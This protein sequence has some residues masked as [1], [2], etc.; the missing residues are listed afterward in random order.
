MLLFWRNGVKNQ[1]HE[2]TVCFLYIINSSFLSVKY[3]HHFESEVLLKTWNIFGMYNFFIS[4]V[5]TT[6]SQNLVVA[7]SNSASLCFSIP[8]LV[9][10]RKTGRTEGE[11]DV[12]I[13]ALRLTH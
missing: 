5:T 13:P 8:H 11:W 4:F 1:H 2:I 12:S 10:P 7:K 6:L 9:G 3:S